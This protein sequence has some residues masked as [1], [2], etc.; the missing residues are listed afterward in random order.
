MSSKAK[1]ADLHCHAVGEEYVAKFQVSV[2]YL[3]GVDI[4]QTVSQ[5]SQVETHLRLS[6][7]LPPFHYMQ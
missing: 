7:R 1:I 6:Q 4:T 5:L 2:D 3:I